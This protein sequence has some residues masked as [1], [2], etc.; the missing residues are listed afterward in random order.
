MLAK[1]VTDRGL[2]G[3][4][5]AVIT[6]QEELTGTM[7]RA[8]SATCDPLPC[9]TKGRSWNLAFYPNHHVSHVTTDSP[10]CPR[11]NTRT[12]CL[13]LHPARD[14]RA[15]P[16]SEASHPKLTSQESP[17][18]QYYSP[19]TSLS[20]QGTVNHPLSPPHTRQSARLSAVPVIPPVPARVRLCS[21][22][23]A[24][25]SVR[26]RLCPRLCSPVSTPVSARARPCP[27]PCPRLYFPVSAPCFYL[28]NDPGTAPGATPNGDECDTVTSR[29]SAL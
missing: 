15:R 21:P 1:I 17:V 9:L 19:R 10:V 28:P 14:R 12:T 13:L 24:P 27:R 16:A 23:S 2:T 18:N 3:A 26:A 29:L 4:Q 11:Y 6:I 20:P 25:V 5:F 8:S 7:T 22:V